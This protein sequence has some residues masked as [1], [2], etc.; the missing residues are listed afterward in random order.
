M[1]LAY[2]RGL[3]STALN[4]TMCIREIYFLCYQ[5]EPRV[6]VRFVT[7]VKNM[8]GI[9]LLPNS[10]YCWSFITAV[11]KQTLI[12]IIEIHTHICTDILYALCNKHRLHNDVPYAVLQLS[13]FSIKF[14]S[15]VKPFRNP[16][17]TLKLTPRTIWWSDKKITIIL[18]HLIK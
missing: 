14:Q 13:A 15:S 18:I 16:T 8:R 6:Y 11:N 7:Y 2:T 10:Y 3:F 4:N 5:N 17:L 9:P 12:L 1:Y